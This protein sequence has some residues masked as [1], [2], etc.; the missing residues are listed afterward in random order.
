VVLTYSASATVLDF[1]VAAR[2]FVQGVIAMESQP[3]G[4]G[5]KF[6][7]DLRARGLRVE[8]ARDAE[9]PSAVARAGLA[10]TG[11]DWISPVHV[12]NKVGTA[13]LCRAARERAAPVY[14]LASKLKMLPFEPPP[15]KSGL[16]E[17]VPRELF[18]ALITEH[19]VSA[20]AVPLSR[21]L[22]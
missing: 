2:S 1:V 12:V 10:L 14:C 6:G 7:Q 8:I 4:E 11:A 13:A 19:G 15:D 9:L 17:P 21:R 20:D 18:T 5:R 3:G 16:F 22:T